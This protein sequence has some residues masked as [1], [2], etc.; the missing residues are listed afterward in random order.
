MTKSIAMPRLSRK[1]V[2][3]SAVFFTLLTLLSLFFPHTAQAMPWDDWVN[4]VGN[5]ITQW[6]KEG[7]LVPSIENMLSMSANMLQNITTDNLLTG[8]FKSLFATGS[9]ADAVWGVIN[10]VHQSLVVPIG[11]SLLA[12]A[13]LVQL[14]KISQ[15]VDATATLPA[16]KEIVILVVFFVVFTYMINHGPQICEG[17]YNVFNDI[18][19]NISG[20]QEIESAVT[21][22]DTANVDVGFLVAMLLVTVLV[23]FATL[24]TAVVAY[25]VSAARAIQLYVMAVFSP[26]PIALLGFE[27]TR[28]MG[29][30]FFKNFAAVCLAGS[31]LVFLLAIFPVVYSA[32]VGSGGNLVDGD[33]IITGFLVKSIGI[34]ILFI[35]AMVKSG[36]WARD[37][38]GG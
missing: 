37:I 6:V 25:V 3:A 33:G 30:N 14:V 32:F 20:N 19:K 35:I 13:I 36:A 12:A 38:L 28:S 10:K 1:T 18:A 7:F 4:D 24:F 22:G 21:L 9:Q 2:I 23:L 16:V 27:E 34:P 8:S 5:N 31:I 26:I 11:H 15:K 29:I 17:I